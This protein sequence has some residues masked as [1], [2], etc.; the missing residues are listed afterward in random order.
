MGINEQTSDLYWIH[1]LEASL[2]EQDFF[3]L[4]S[5]SPLST[6]IAFEKDISEEISLFGFS[7]PDQVITNEF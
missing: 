5:S 3:S 1:S 7:S 6:D 2:P 4:T